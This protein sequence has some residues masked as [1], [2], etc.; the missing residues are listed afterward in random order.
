MSKICENFDSI[1]ILEEFL[2]IIKTNGYTSFN[3]SP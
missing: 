2:E 3:I 1:R